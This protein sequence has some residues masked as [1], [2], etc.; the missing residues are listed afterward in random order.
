MFFCFHVILCNISVLSVCVYLHMCFVSI[1][2]CLHVCL[3]VSLYMC[4]YMFCVCMYVSVDVFFVF[5]CS[6]VGDGYFC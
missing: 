2:F 1:S 5:V 3:S 4:I 6:C